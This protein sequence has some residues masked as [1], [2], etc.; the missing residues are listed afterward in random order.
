MKKEL[1]KIRKI[2]LTDLGSVEVD[3][4]FTFIGIP[5]SEAIRHMKDAGRER[6][7]G[8]VNVPIEATFDGI[9]LKE[10]RVLKEVL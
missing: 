9:M 3:L 4:G 1:G 2:D 10:W 7:Q 6:L 8:M 5:V